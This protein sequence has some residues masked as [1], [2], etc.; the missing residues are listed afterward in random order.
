PFPPPPGGSGPGPGFNNPGAPFLA[1]TNSGPKYW[2]GVRMPF[3][4]ISADEQ[5][6]R[7][8][9]MFVSQGFFTNPFF[10]D[11]RPWLAMGGAA[12]FITALC[13][14]PLMH[15]LT[16]S[17][18]AMKRATA[19]IA[20]GQ[21]D[22]ELRGA[23]R[24][25]LGLLGRSISQMAS[26]LQTFTEGRKRFLGDVAHELRSPIARMQLA[27]EIL[28]RHMEAAAQKYIDSLKDDLNIMTRLTDELLEFA[29]AEKTSHG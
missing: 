21:F 9:L 26:R 19:R 11:L 18:A 17:I 13:W 27:T 20:E 24:D 4:K 16:H 29:R 5:P 23:R 28:E 10:F 22:V 25:E 6:L 12:L 15:N 7:S 8:V 2:V 3:I 1:V 14:L